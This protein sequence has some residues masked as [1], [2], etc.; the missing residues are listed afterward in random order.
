M[1]RRLGKFLPIVLIALLVQIFAPV[2]RPG[3]ERSRFRSAAWGRHLPW[4]RDF[5]SRAISPASPV[6]TTAVR[7]ATWPKPARPVDT[8][9]AAFT[10][11]PIARPR[12]RGLA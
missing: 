1:R 3:R 5:G 2:G 7:F 9:R 10:L 4:R 6:P 8:T 11:G 12:T